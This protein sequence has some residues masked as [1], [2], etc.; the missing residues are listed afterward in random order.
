MATDRPTRG[1][2]SVPWRDARAS[3]DYGRV[4]AAV[5]GAAGAVPG[6][7]GGQ[8][9]T[10]VTT[11]LQKGAPAP[12]R[13]RSGPL[14]QPGATMGVPRMGAVPPTRRPYADGT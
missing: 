14:R 4:V 5:P 8:F 11:G 7:F 2:K 1:F 3:Q 6:G 9:V 13:V 10:Y 12:R